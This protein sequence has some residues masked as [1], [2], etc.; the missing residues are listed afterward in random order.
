MIKVSAVQFI[1]HLKNIEENIK[2]IKSYLEEAKNK[3]SD[4]VLFPELSVTGYSLNEDSYIYG[5][6][7]DN[8]LPEIQN[9]CKKLKINCVISLPLNEKDNTYIGAVFIDSNGIIK[10]KYLKTHLYDKESKFFSKGQDFPVFDTPIGKIGMMI[11]YDLEFPEVARI[12][13]LKGAELILIPTSNMSPYEEDQTIFVKSRTKEN[14]V[15]ILICNRLGSEDDLNFFGNSMLVDQEGKIIF[16]AKDHSGIFTGK[17]TKKYVNPK[18]NYLT[19]LQGSIYNQ[20]D[21][22]LEEYKNKKGELYE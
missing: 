15:P 10:S 19:N 13:S 11:C 1:P 3:N 14:E 21:V 16:D 22:S 8:I 6:Q 18:L 9:L 20:L 4:L 12:L 2:L 7:E 5:M 17:L